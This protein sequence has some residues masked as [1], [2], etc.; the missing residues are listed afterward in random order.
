M[1]RYPLPQVD[2]GRLA[3]GVG[4]RIESFQGTAHAMS[5]EL[6]GKVSHVEYVPSQELTLPDLSDT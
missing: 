2:E 6:S 5:W 1:S 3:F 4:R